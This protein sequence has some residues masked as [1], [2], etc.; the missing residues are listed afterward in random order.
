MRVEG[1][2]LREKLLIDVR[3]HR[4][5][6]HKG[7]YSAK[8]QGLIIEDNIMQN[9]HLYIYIY[10]HIDDMRKC[11]VIFKFTITPSLSCCGQVHGHCGWPVGGD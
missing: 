6:D 3:I 5:F 11:E 9:E 1:K 10:I 2:R 8:D 4:T 7:Q